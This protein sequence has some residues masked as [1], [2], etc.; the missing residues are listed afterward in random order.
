MLSDDGIDA[1]CHTG[2]IYKYH[3]LITTL[4]LTLKMITAEVVETSVTTTSLSQD[5][6]HWN[7]HAGQTTDTLGYKPFTFSHIYIL[8]LTALSLKSKPWPQLIH[9][10][11]LIDDNI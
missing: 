8:K 1:S 7:N 2:I 3:H 11:F 9:V 5:Y 6:P 10:V 4:H